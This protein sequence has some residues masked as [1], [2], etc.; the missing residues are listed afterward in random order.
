MTLYPADEPNHEI[1]DLLCLAV[2]GSLL[3][4]LQLCLVGNLKAGGNPADALSPLI[5]CRAESLHH[6]P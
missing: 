6:Q 3:S 4:C 1:A 5:H 2:Q